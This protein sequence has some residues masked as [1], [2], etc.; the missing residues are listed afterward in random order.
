MC[1]AVTPWN[2]NTPYLPIGSIGCLVSETH[3][4]PLCCAWGFIPWLLL[5][6][7]QPV[8][9]NSTRVHGAYT[10]T[11]YQSHLTCHL[12]LITWCKLTDCIKNTTAVCNLRQIQSE[13]K[14]SLFW[15]S[16]KKFSDWF[17][18]WTAFCL[19]LNLSWISSAL[20]WAVSDLSM[21]IITKQ[22]VH[23]AI[24]SKTIL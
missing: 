4:P 17:L 3:V 9:G 13:T 22:Y 2:V 5:Y 18:S 23:I 14:F 19:G 1:H 21:L 8:V 6:W 16:E 7:L 12:P 15:P 10:R 24:T 11:M 20:F